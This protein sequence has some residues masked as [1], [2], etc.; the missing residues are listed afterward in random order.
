MLA[1]Y[2]TEQSQLQLQLHHR[3]VTITI[4]TNCTRFTEPR[5]IIVKI[6]LWSYKDNSCSMLILILTV[7]SLLLWSILW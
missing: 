7:L 2:T 4:I 3:T 6:E 5:Y 1:T